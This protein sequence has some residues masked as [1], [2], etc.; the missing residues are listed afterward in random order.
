VLDLM[1]SLSRTAGS[2]LLL[3]THSM[4]LA[5]KLNRKV[6]LRGGKIVS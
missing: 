5:D 6:F 2:A 3:V 4:R 1:L